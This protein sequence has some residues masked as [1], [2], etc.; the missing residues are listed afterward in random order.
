MFRHRYPTRA[1]VIGKT[2]LRNANGVRSLWDNVPCIPC[3]WAQK[4]EWKCQLPVPGGEEGLGSGDIPQGD[5]TANRCEPLQASSQKTGARYCPRKNVKRL[6][7][8]SRWSGL[9]CNDCSSANAAP[10]AYRLS[11]SHP[12]WLLMWNVVSPQVSRQGK[13]AARDA[14]GSAGKAS[15]ASSGMG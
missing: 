7:Q 9:E 2:I 5:D 13:Q 8:N 14:D 15:P 6:D 11:L 12:L 4:R 1:C 3:G 10:S